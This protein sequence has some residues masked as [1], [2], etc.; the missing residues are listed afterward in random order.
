LKFADELGLFL[1]VER[2]VRTVLRGFPKGG[3][4]GVVDFG[5]AV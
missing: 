4:A 1:C 3:S 2:H 5:G